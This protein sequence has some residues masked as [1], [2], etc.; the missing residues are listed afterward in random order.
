M[1]DRVKQ[2][3]ARLLE[4]WNKF[5]SKQKTVIVSVA[6][7]VV[8]AVAILMTMITRPQYE[9]LIVC[10]TTKEAAEIKDLLD[11]ESIKYNISNDGFTIQVL[12]E[13][14]SDATLLLGANNYPTYGYGIDNVFDGGF[15]STEAD[16]SKKYKLYMEDKMEKDLAANEL[17]DSANA[18]LSIPEDDGTLIAEKEEAYASI[19]LTLNG[20]MS[21]ETAASLARFVATALGNKTTENIVLL[22]STGNLLFSGEDDASTS[23]GASNRLSFKSQYETLVKN[24]IKDALVIPKIYDNVQVVPNLAL[25]W[26]VINEVTHEY[27]APDGQTQGVYSHEENFE[28]ESSGGNGGV[29]GTDANDQDVEDTYVIDQTGVTQSTQ[30]EYSRDYLPNER[31]TTTDQA[32]GAI[33]YD[34]SSLGI[35]AIHYVV[36][37]EADLRTQ[38]LLDGM[39]FDEFRLANSDRVK[40]DVDQDI[41]NVVAM[42]TGI[43]VGNISIVA[44]DEPLFIEDDSTGV[45]ASDIIQIGLIILILG[46]LGFVVFRSMRP[47]KTEE[48]EEELSLDGLLQSTQ[49]AQG[50][51]DIDL[52]EKSE[53]RTLIEKFVD[54]SPDAVANLLR[55]WL[56]E[57]WG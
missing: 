31:I 25:D 5:T 43:P 52:G 50:L 35:T 44:Y 41:Y 10:E 56:T 39:T 12:K 30:A 46:L 53:V 45:T 55:N 34:T 54:E 21:N 33:L 13:D 37:N 16:K 8:V 24:E 32:G 40:T 22:D 38:G 14:L 29:P 15:S 23:G 28:S 26:S 47:E 9:T 4:W 27:Y 36:Y 11:G 20:E 2:I 51:E 17:V 49:E 1:A 6:A 7:G 3:P 57:D 18:T 19:I 48:P 42:A